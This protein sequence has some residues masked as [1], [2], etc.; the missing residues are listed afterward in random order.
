MKNLF[1]GIL[2]T[3]VSFNSYA[4][5]CEV[6]T[7]KNGD[8][9]YDDLV[10]AVPSVTDKDMI[11]IFKNGGVTRQS[12]ID[13]GNKKNFTLEKTAI[14]SGFEGTKIIAFGTNGSNV[15]VTAQH[16]AGTQQDFESLS[17]G[18][19]DTNAAYGVLIDYTTKLR[20]ACFK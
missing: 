14:T 8:G 17:A 19:F 5:D 4:L 6:S 18:A 9:N 12:G 3:M 2:L 13:I 20:V 7:D 15:V 16:V 10:V 11:F 1:F